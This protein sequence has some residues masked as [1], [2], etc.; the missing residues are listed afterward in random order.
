MPS[1]IY[2]D[3]LKKLKQLEQIGKYN[4]KVMKNN[5]FPVT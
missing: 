4:I 3:G 5:A 1:G 2:D